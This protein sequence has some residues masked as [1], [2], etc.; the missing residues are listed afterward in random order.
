MRKA[1]EALSV[2]QTHATYKV[3]SNLENDS[4]N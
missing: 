4:V 1:W 3:K 2:S